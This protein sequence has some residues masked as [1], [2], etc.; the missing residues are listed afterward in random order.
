MTRLN[1]VNAARLP[2]S[3]A[4][5]NYDRSAVATGIVHLGVGAFHKAHQAA[6]Y[7][8]ALNSGDLRWGV[9][10]AS[11]RSPGV[12]DQLAP[13]DN[14]YTISAREGDATQTQLIERFNQWML[15]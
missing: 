12:R 1:D 4:R 10:G 5:P 9:L 13:Q 14:L 15:T 3:V 7:E 8:A 11:L 2:A 6:V